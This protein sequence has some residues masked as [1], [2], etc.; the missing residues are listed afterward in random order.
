MKIS[1]FVINDTQRINVS[2]TG[3]SIKIGTANESDVKVLGPGNTNFIEISVYKTEIHIKLIKKNALIKINNKLIDSD[4]EIFSGDQIE[5]YGVKIDLSVESEELFISIDE[6]GS[7][8]LTKA[9]EFE[10]EQE[11]SSYEKI[12]AKNYTIKRDGIKKD[13]KIDL[14]NW[15]ITV[16]VIILFLVSSSYY[17]FNSESVKFEIQPRDVDFFSIQ[18]GWFKIPLGD[19]YLLRP[20]DYSVEIKKDGFYPLIQNFIVTDEVNQIVPISLKKLPGIVNIYTNTNDE[21]QIYIDDNYIAVNQAKELK[22]DSGYHKLEITSERFLLYSGEIFVRGMNISQDIFVEMIPGWS[23]IRLESRPS[24]ADIYKADVKI[25]QTPASIN[26]MEGMHTITLLKDGFNAW[27]R[28]FSVVANTKENIGPIILEPANAELDITTIPSGANVNLDGMYRGQSPLKVSLNPNQE[29]TFSFSKNGFKT[30]DRQFKLNSAEKRA[31]T[32]DLAAIF[33][34]ISILLNE[35]DADVFINQKKVGSGSMILDLPATE[36]ALTITKP[37]Y[38]TFTRK[39]N[40]RINYPQK[41]EVNIL[42]EEEYRSQSVIKFILNSQEQEL[43]RIDPGDFTMGSSRREVG[44]RAN[45]VIRNVEITQSYFISTKEVTNKDFSKFRSI[46]SQPAD[47]HP[48]L[49]ADNNPVVSISWSDAIEYCNW[50]SDSEGLNPAYAKRF[51]KWELIEPL[52][53]GYRLPTEAEWVWAIKYQSRNSNHIFPW[54]NRFPPRNDYGNYADTA[55]QKLLPNIIPNYN[56]GYSSSSPV[57]SFRSNSLGIYDGSGNVSEWISDY[58]SIPTPGVPDVIKDP[59]GP[60]SGTQH[61]IRGS[62]WRHANITQLRHSY[63][64]FGNEGRIDVGFRIARN[65]DD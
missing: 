54:G 57:G 65:T 30:V 41:I 48:S 25:G 52:T 13:K 11:Y 34:Q 56:D 64:D 43:R 10:N 22:L 55:A 46:S 29:Y 35:E 27:D 26:L 1:N 50:L 59:R 4:R 9:P 20:G 6:K 39:I 21:S 16:S 18:G 63:R 37:G 49:I 23:E 5:F 61:V 42:S 60:K 62:S 28:T 38:K 53:N 31:V 2:S 58:Y 15:K 36:H 24:G 12:H 19:R 44:R 17:I 3:S 14:A 8:Y 33:G 40:P 47:V 32:I 45:E 7:N 51:E